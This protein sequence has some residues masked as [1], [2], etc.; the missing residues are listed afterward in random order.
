MKKRYYK[1]PQKKLRVIPLGGLGEVGKNMMVLEYSNNIII[2][3]AGLMF[4]EDEMLGIDFV[5]PNVNYLEQRKNKIRGLL[6]THG[7]EDHIGA[8]P[9]ILPKISPP[10]YCT[11]LTRGL[12]EVKLEEFKVTRPYFNTI[13]P[14][15]V[16]QL[17]C[18]K[19]EFFRV[20]HSIPDGVG[21]AIYTPVGL[22]VH[23]G[24]FKFDTSQGEGKNTDIA[25]V[26]QLSKKGVLALFSDSCNSEVPGYTPSEKLLEETFDHIFEKA[27]GR[28]IVA[29]FASQISRIQQI[30]NA[31]V[32]RDKKV[33]ISGLSMV[34]NI[35]IATKLGYLK[36]PRE[37]LIKIQNIKKFPD[38]KIVILSTGSQGEAMSALA[39]MSSGEHKQIKIKKGDTVIISASPI[40]GNERSISAVIDDL[41][42]EGANVIYDVKMQVHVSGHPCQEDLKMMIGF[43]KPKYFIPIH[44]EYHHLIHHGELAQDVGIPQN[45]ILIAENGNVIEFTP[46]YGKVTGEKVPCGYVMVDGLGVGDVGNIVLRDRQTMAKDGIFVVILTI[47][48][49]TGKLVCNP[50]IISRGF[51]YMRESEELIN[52]T[53]Q[54]ARRCLEARNSS[55]PSNWTFIK[56]KIRD[57]IGAFLYNQTKRRP[58]VLPVVIEV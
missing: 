8:I 4:P 50:D 35:D 22:L 49:K 40:P 26:S 55:Y 7:H 13:K 58:M 34:R 56:S 46:N 54:K 12:I 15:D 1:N 44:G 24:D 29:S 32:E 23:T 33:T 3:D 37:T 19:V 18:F 48:R 45:K 11:R 43:T 42:R 27:K 17:G 47:D 10:I 5:I 6:V 20:N 39:R 51:V 16:I 57:D 25:F 38:N 53:R 2:I 36:I 9:Y 14:G 52:K 21:L 41:F 28:I 31:A 30:V